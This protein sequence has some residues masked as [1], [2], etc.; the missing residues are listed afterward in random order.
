MREIIIILAI[1]GLVWV[2]IKI[3]IWLICK[4]REKFLDLGRA[5]KE[6]KNSREDLYNLLK[7][8]ELRK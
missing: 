3:E 4:S 8:K 5:Y 2:F 7:S 1:I 6:L